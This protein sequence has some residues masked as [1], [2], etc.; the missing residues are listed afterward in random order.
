MTPYGEIVR[1]QCGTAASGYR[2]TIMVNGSPVLADTHLYDED[3]NK[4]HSIRIYASGTSDVNTGCAPM[5]YLLDISMKP[6]KVI[7]FGVKSAC[8]EFH[9]ASW[10][11]K[12]SVIALK[13]NVEFVYENGKLSPP[14]RGEKLF[15]GIEPPRSS[16]GGGMTE[17]SAIPFVKEVPLPKQ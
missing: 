13:K 12:R 14:S 7:A 6:A 17:E 16:V 8:N 1:F 3:S 5:L 9:W 2:E 4:D 15:K 11:A 10:G